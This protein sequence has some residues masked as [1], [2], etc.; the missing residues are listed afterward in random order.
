[1]KLKKEMNI[2][3]VLDYI[4]H[5]FKYYG[6]DNQGK[7]LNVRDDLI[8]KNVFYNW[9]RRYNEKIKR[10]N[11]G[12]KQRY[13]RPTDEITNKLRKQIIPI[14]KSKGNLGTLY[15]IQ[16]V[17]L[18]INEKRKDL[19]EQYINKTEEVL[20][21]WS[22]DTRTVKRIPKS[23]RQLGEANEDYISYM[24]NL[25][26]NELKNQVITKIINLIID[27]DKLTTDCKAY[28]NGKITEI[29]IEDY[30]KI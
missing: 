5:Q 27:K 17:N 2:H 25:R 4:N 7:A 12:I 28:L 10:Y 9:I 21:G 14:K 8:T 13:Q 24:D 30:Y 29:D 19:E 20:V 1:M 11:E 15:K 26:V 6:L 16:D 23:L 18:L 22:E 3:E